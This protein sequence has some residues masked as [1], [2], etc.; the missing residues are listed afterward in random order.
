MTHGLHQTNELLLVRRELE[1]T[2]GEGPA[3]ISERTFTLVKDGAEPHPGGIA[4]DHERPCEVRHLENGARREGPLEGLECRGGLVIPDERIAT[5]EA[6]ERCRDEAEVPD[7]FPV[8]PGETQEAAQ[9][10]RRTR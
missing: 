8:V 2:C 5:Q 10:A 4:V 6:R 1:V 9:G 3:E 7:K